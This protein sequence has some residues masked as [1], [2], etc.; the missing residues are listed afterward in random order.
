M[1]NKLKTILLSS[2]KWCLFFY[3]WIGLGAC[4]SH[5]LPNVWGKLPSINSQIG[6]ERQFRV[7][8]EDQRIKYNQGIIARRQNQIQSAKN[9]T[10]NER[11][12]DLSH[13]QQKVYLYM[14]SI[15]FLL[16]IIFMNLEPPR[17]VI[18]K[19]IKWLFKG[20]SGRSD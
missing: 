8:G 12:I 4:T 13:T 6:G 17:I 1:L 5:L 18:K 7:G 16:V 10:L 19:V 3:F 15:L 20:S 2:I 14:I 11:V 9:I